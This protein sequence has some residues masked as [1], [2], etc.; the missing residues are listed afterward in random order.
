MPSIIGDDRNPNLM[1]ALLSAQ[2]DITGADNVEIQIREDKK[3]IWVNVQGVCV[4]RICQIKNLALT[5]ER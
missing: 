2:L 5:D 1:D 4:L 3:V